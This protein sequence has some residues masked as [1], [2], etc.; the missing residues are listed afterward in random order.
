MVTIKRMSQ[1]LHCK[2]VTY[3]L[4]GFVSISSALSLAGVG[5]HISQLVSLPALGMSADGVPVKTS[6]GN[7]DKY[8]KGKSQL[9]SKINRDD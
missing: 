9:L 4:K 5:S 2:W 1:K 3:A 8:L 6:S 7:G